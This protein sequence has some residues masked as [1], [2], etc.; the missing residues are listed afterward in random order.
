VELWL[1]KILNRTLILALLNFLIYIFL[2]TYS[3]KCF[4]FWVNFFFDVTKGGDGLLQAKYESKIFKKNIILLYFWL[5]TLTIY[6][7]MEIFKK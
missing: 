1:L 4:N 5:N 3:N 7:N 6:R 2:A